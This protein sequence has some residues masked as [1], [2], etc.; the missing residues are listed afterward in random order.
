MPLFDRQ[1]EL[2]LSIPHSAGIIGIGGVGSWVALNLALVGV[3]EIVLVDPDIVEEHNRNRTLFTAAQVGEP[4]VV[5]L[6]SLIME[7]R[8]TSVIPI[9]KMIEDLSRMELEFL[10]KCDT[11]VDCRDTSEP[12]PEVLRKKVQ[13]I[14]GYNGSNITMHINPKLNSIWGDERAGYTITPSWLVPPAL[15]ATL[16]CGYITMPNNKFKKEVIKSFDIGDLIKW[17]D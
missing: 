1:S 13:I 2:N 7:R 10:I 12:L 16:I 9:E 4:K 8:E 5:A 6:M 14:G 17:L 3:E 11:I 15:I